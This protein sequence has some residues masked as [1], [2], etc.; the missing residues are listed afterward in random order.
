MRHQIL[1]TP[2]LIGEI[3]AV[4]Q[5]PSRPL[6]PSETVS[7]GPS[8]EMQRQVNSNLPVIYF[9]MRRH[10]TNEAYE[11]VALGDPHPTVPF[12]L[13]AWRLQSPVSGH[14]TR[15]Q[16]HTSQGLCKWTQYNRSTT[17]PRA[18]VSG[19]NTRGQQHTS[20]GLCKW[21]QYNRSTTH[22]RASVSGHNTIGQQHT[23]QGLCKWT[24]YNRSTT[25][26]P[27]PL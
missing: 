12:F 6:W 17:H 22:P 9:D 25:H 5:P 19:H 7:K 2:Q 26:L 24:Q 27:G 4:F 20:Q 3:T 18:S 16:Q 15:G 23:S 21:T 10:G 14:N 11:F 1:N 8:A 13:P